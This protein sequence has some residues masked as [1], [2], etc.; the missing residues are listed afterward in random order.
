MKYKFMFYGYENMTA[1]DE[2]VKVIFETKNLVEVDIADEY[3]DN[4]EFVKMATYLLLFHPDLY[5]EYDVLGSTGSIVQ[6]GNLEGFLNPEFE[7]EEES[8]IIIDSVY[9]DRV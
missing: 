1:S 2:E 9:A 8:R 4:K 6:Q 7:D 5:I 3:E